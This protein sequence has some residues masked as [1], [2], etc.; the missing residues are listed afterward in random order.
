MHAPLIDD[1]L[2]RRNALILA[3]AQALAG[4]NATVIFATGAIIGAQLAPDPAYATVPIS[5]FVL[6]MAS[7]TLPVGAIARRYGR[8][9]AFM[10][11][12]GAGALTGLLACLAI[13]Q[14]S[15]AL[16]SL[17]TFFGGFYAA[18]AQSFR[19]AAADTASPGFRP[20]AIS[21]VMAGGV[22]AGVFGPQLIQ[23]TMDVWPPYVFAASYLAQA[24]VALVAMA[25]LS[26]VRIPLPPRGPNA[27]GGARP[28]AMIIRQPRFIVA[29]LCG[30]ISYAL[31]NLVMTSAPLAMRMCGHP[32]SDS[33]LAIQWHVI[34][35]Y[36]PSFFTGSLIARFGAPRV[37][38]T[39]L[40]LLIG[41]GIVDIAGVTVAHF[42]SGLILLGLGWNFGFIGA[43]ALVTESCEPAERTRVQAFNDFLVF[44]TMAIGSFSSGHILATAGWAAVNQVVFLP[45]LLGLGLL[46][47]RGMRPRLAA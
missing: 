10:T 24:V 41:A 30:V 15:F 43:S 38:A 36:G 6:G 29:A 34:A 19:F 5:I 42:W 27:G 47:W 23:F 37:I 9:A 39:G 17:A 16:F 21:Y 1:R 2:A 4:A 22:V 28:L 31:M 13:L 11:G 14:G 20:R 35:M 7:G 33:N 45:A 8:R 18:V 26:R 12:A 44:G 3:I 25:V 32:L 40:V 46:A